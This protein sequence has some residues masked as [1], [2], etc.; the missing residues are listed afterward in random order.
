VRHRFA[1]AFITNVLRAT[2]A[3]KIALILPFIVL[4]FDLEIFYYSLMEKAVNIMIASS[5]VLFLSI[6]EIVAVIEEIYAYVGKMRRRELIEDDVLDAIKSIENPTVREVIEY[7]MD[8]DNDY[9]F[10]ELYPVVCKI[11]EVIKKE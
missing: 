9:T 8:K 6:L 1:R 10:Q 11:I 2:R 3:E 4:L 5:F 7:I